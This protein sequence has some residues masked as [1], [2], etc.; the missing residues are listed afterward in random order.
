MISFIEWM[1]YAEPH[2]VKNVDDSRLV[3]FIPFLST[4]DNADVCMDT[5][6]N[7][8]VKICFSA[9]LALLGGGGELLFSEE[10]QV[11]LRDWNM[12]YLR[13]VQEHELE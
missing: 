5:I 11:L 9:L 6:G 10:S 1:W 2:R 3:Y 12:T 4:D 8:D 7:L 13:M